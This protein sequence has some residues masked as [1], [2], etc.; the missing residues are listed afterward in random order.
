MTSAQSADFLV[1]IGQLPEGCRPK[2]SLNVLCQGSSREVWLLDINESGVVRASRYR[3]G[4]TS[5]A[6]TTGVWFP[7][8]TTFLV[9]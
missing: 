7:F 5:V 2:R 8:T 6:V 3:K 1:Q 9:A 4:D